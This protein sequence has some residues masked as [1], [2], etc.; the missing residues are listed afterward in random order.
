MTLNNTEDFGM[1]ENTGGAAHK[2][3]ALILTLG[4]RVNHYESEAI[5]E[6]L[7]RTGFRVSLSE[8]SGS[9][10]DTVIVNTCSVTAMSDRKSR[11]CI[12]R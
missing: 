10:Y 8:E 2:R 4:C 6:H 3:S 11:S 12:A 9:G 1:C 7:R 5:A